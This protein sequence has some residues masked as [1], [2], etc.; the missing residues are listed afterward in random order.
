MAAEPLIRESG[1]SE[2]VTEHDCSSI[3]RRSNQMGDVLAAGCK[4]EKGLGMRRNRLVGC[5][6]EES[7]PDGFSHLGPA[8][9]PGGD[10]GVSSFPKRSTEEKHLCAFPATF[11]AFQGEE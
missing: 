10:H 8:W 3:E 1:I 11:G 7:F 4:H 5:C 6:R 2:A 9:F